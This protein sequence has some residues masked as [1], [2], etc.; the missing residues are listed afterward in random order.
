ME[1]RKNKIGLGGHALGELEADVLVIVCNRWDERHRSTVK[2]VYQVLNKDRSLDYM[3][4][5]TTVMTVMTR[6]ATKGLVAQDQATIPYL[7]TPKVTVDEVVNELKA[8]IDQR[9]QKQL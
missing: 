3:L 4:A 8:E 7:Y 5:Y 1:R 6:M 9:F 2:D